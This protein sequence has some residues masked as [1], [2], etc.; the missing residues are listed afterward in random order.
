LQLSTQ[1]QALRNSGR[2]T[3]VRGLGIAGSIGRQIENAPTDAIA[4]Q[5]R[6]LGIA[7]LQGLQAGPDIPDRFVTNNPS[8]TRRSRFTTGVA[9][10]TREDS[11][12]ST[13]VRKIG[14]KLD[15][16]IDL[17]ESGDITAAN[18]RSAVGAE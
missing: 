6:E 17:L 8:L 4:E 1:R 18:L 12:T 9:Q 7:Q 13:E 15:R 16:L 10:A 14:D 5:L 3:A 2:G 11:G